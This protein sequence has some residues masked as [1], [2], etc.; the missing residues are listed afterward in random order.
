MS[1]IRA[2][3][4]INCF[5]KFNNSS[6]T[7]CFNEVFIF[8]FKQ[9]YIFVWQW[10]AF[11][12]IKF[13]ICNSRYVLFYFLL[14]LLSLRVLL[15]TALCVRLN[16]SVTLIDE[17]KE[18]FLKIKKTGYIEAAEEVSIWMAPHIERQ[19]YACYFALRWK[20]QSYLKTFRQ[21]WFWHY[22]LVL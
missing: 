18:S 21:N 16:I 7:Y 13:V 14:L 2:L 11:H 3:M 10:R 5:F 9:Q 6:K 15:I 12:H 4:L 20:P 19:C 8:I 22:P 17:L 1:S